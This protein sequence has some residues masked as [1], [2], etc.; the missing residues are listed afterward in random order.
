[1]S[2][3]RDSNYILKVE[4]M[5]FPD[6]QRWAVVYIDCCV[7]GGLELRIREAVVGPGDNPFHGLAEFS[8]WEFIFSE[9]IKAICFSFVR[10][11]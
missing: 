5:G 6:A 7:K 1:M 11:K 3:I 8:H 9:I 2:W 10:S 4:P